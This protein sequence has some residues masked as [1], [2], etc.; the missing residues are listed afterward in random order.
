M[1]EHRFIFIII[2]I[3]LPLFLFCLTKKEIRK[4]DPL[5]QRIYR[6]YK[7][8]PRKLDKDSIIP[9]QYID[10][11][12]HISI[13]YRTSYSKSEL[14]EKNI[15]VQ[16]KAGDIAASIINF[17]ELETLLQDKNIFRLEANTMD[18]PLLE[19]STSDSTKTGTEGTVY[20][21]NNADASQTAGYDGTGIVAAVI[22]P[23]G[24]RFTHEDFQKDNGD[25][26]IYYIWDQFTGSGGSNHPTGYTYGTEYDSVA[27]NNGSCNQTPGYH[28]NTCIGIMAGDGSASPNGK[29]YSAM[30]PNAD[31]IYVKGSSSASSTYLQ[32]GVEYIMN[33][34][35][36][37]GKPA[38]VN[39]S[40]G[41]QYG[42]HDGTTLRV[43]AIDNLC[44]PGK[45]VVFACGNSGSQRI[46]AQTTIAQDG[47][48]TFDID[49][50]T[51]DFGIDLWFSGNDTLSVYLDSPN[52][53]EIGPISYD[54]T[55]VDTTNDG[56]REI[57]NCTDDPSNGDHHIV[58]YV[59]PTE[60]D[61]FAT[62]TW[63]VKLRGDSIQSGQIDGWSF[64][65]NGNY[66][67]SASG[68]NTSK[69]LNDLA[70]G[71][72]T[73]AAAG[74]YGGELN[75]S[76]TI[77]SGSGRGPTRD[78]RQKPDIAGNMR[79][80]VPHYNDDTTYYASGSGTSYAAPHVAGAIALMLQKQPSAAPS[81]IKTNLHDFA[82]TDE[83]TD[84]AGTEPNYQIGYG[85]LNTFRSVFP[86]LDPPDSVNIMVICNGDSLQIT[87]LNKGYI[88]YIYSSNDPY[89]NFPG[90]SWV[91]ET[92]ITDSGIITLPIEDSDIKKYFLITAD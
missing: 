32:D 57:Y 88:Y 29:D 78:G 49:V 65:Y 81:D 76:G 12:P 89:A 58:V 71:N 74:F 19:V 86:A 55:Y 70:S 48:H 34:A 92:S 37:L 7:Q 4:M 5:L 59:S 54:S 46:H 75:D 15:P 50:A 83:Y 73:I 30:A 14:L 20:I 85:K 68:G 80:Y 18:F 79:V 87:W 21:G 72:Q 90:S 53:A 31:I 28:G 51:D 43:E 52:L 82:F 10:N 39:I 16:S 2:L 84:N 25:T 6:I 64:T 66:F 26:R 11:I 23:Y 56:I 1:K 41:N 69:T 22:D 13:S 27:I 24:I 38:V 35:S 17:E 61:S 62:G 3:F 8:N 36:T 40:L 77:Y 47:F 60:A 63:K 42:A 33:K 45:I 67:T 9:I 91:L 44:G